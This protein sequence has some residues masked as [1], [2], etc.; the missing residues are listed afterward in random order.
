MRTRLLTKD[1]KAING[2]WGKEVI[3]FFG[4][5]ATGKLSMPHSPTLMQAA[6]NQLSRSTER[7]ETD[8]KVGEGWKEEGESKDHRGGLR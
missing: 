4:N 1:L 2:C 6:P 8:V 5:I 7:G 3:F